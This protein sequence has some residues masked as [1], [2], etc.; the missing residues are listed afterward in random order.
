[1]PKEGCHL[2]QGG[3]KGALDEELELVSNHELELREGGGKGENDGMREA[4]KV[5]TIE[6][7]REGKKRES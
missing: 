5:G 1:M 2:L 6:G 7:R 3:G 4:G